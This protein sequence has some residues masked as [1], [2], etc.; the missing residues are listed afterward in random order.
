MKKFPEEEV[1]S[2]KSDEE[3]PRRRATKTD[4]NLTQIRG[5]YHL[6]YSSWD[7]ALNDATR[8]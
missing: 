4:Q 7:I 2:K 8:K 5:S 6:K 3:I 1:R